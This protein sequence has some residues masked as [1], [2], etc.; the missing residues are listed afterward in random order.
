MDGGARCILACCCCCGGEKQAWNASAPAAIYCDFFSILPY[1]QHE[2]G[3]LLL[4]NLRVAARQHA[5][6]VGER[7]TCSPPL[8]DERV[9]DVQKAVGVHHRRLPRAKELCELALVLGASR[10]ACLA[11]I[12]RWSRLHRLMVHQRRGGLAA[13][14]ELC[15][16][17]AST[18]HNLYT[19]RAATGHG[20]RSCCIGAPWLAASTGHNARPPTTGHQK[21]SLNRCRGSLHPSS[22]VNRRAFD[23]FEAKHHACSAVVLLSTTRAGTHHP[24]LMYFQTMHVGVVTF[25]DKQLPPPNKN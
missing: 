22:C 23:V 11:P 19:H 16:Q 9:F 1:L 3:M 12:W 25:F 6:D 8:E 5:G 24:D 21:W 20:Q 10:G 7:A 2:V 17:H 18:E 13:C 4:Q 15:N 14:V